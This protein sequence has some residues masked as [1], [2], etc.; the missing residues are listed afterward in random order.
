MA[1]QYV[2]VQFHPSDRRTYTYHNDG[3]RVERGASV[4]VETK[5]GPAQAQVVAV[6]VP[7]PAFDTKPITWTLV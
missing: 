7:Q 2:T 4:T 1:R 5:R 3:P 6:D